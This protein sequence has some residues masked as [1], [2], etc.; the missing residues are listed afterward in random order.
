MD[1]H[2]RRRSAPLLAVWIIALVAVVAGCGLFGGSSPGAVGTAGPERPKIK[3]GAMT[4]ID[5]APVW[6]AQQKGYFAQEGLD[7][8]LETVA[9]AAVAVPK[10][11]SGDLQFTYGAYVPYFQAQAKG[12]ADLKIVAD[13]YQTAANIFMIMV[14]RTSPIRSPKDLAGKRIATN[15]K[16]SITD[17]LAKSALD[18]N[19]VDYSSV[20]W[21]EFPFPD[22]QAR[23]ADGTVDAA[24]MLE[25]YVTQAERSIGA[26]PVLDTSSGP[27]ANFPISGYAGSAKFVNDNPRTT[28]AFRRALTRASTDAQQRP[29]V[30]A[31]VE[32]YAK[33]DRS[34]ASLVGIGTF[35]TSIDRTRLQRTLDL[36]K[37]YQMLTADVDINTMLLDTP[38][39]K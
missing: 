14:S 17:L 19:G 5:S 10:L 32:Q 9:G 34:V 24:I 22:M 1:A 3:V 29:V 4:I 37:R 35:P 30:E 31:A 8:Q 38:A 16:N 23:L 28:E 33:I 12:A 20:T 6:I 18:T 36:M 15:T 2:I 11:V 27:T 25:P 7:V 26:T 13:S 39:A 21:V